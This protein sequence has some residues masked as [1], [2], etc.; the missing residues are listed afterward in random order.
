MCLLLL[1]T[2]P[3]FAAAPPGVTHACAPVH[4]LPRPC[5][6]ATE[7][8]TGTT[9][10]FEVTDATLN[11][12]NGIDANSIVATLSRPGAPPVT[13]F[14][15]NQVWGAGFTGRVIPQFTEN[16]RFG[17]GF[18]IVPAAPL[19]PSTTHTVTVTGNNSHGTPLDPATTS[20]SFTTR[21]SLGGAAL[22]WAVDAA[23]A[24]VNWEG[25][26]FAGECKV[27]FDSSRTYQQEAVY[28]LIDAARAAAPEFFL[29]QRDFPLLGDY[30]QATFFDGNLN[31]VR[32]RETRRITKFVDAAT[33]TELTLGELI[34]GPLYGI[35]PG[36][37]LSGDY[38]A[39]DRVLVCD[40]TRSETKKVQSVNDGARTIRVDK[41]TTPAALWNLGDPVLPADDPTIPDNFTHPLAALRKASPAGTPVYY[42]TRMD[43]EL[44][45]HVAHG[46][47]PLID[48]HDTP[49]DLCRTGVG[50]NSN[51]GTCPSSP[52]DWPEWH[53]FVRTVVGHLIDRYGA[54]VEEWN[55][56]IGNEPD[57]S[58]WWSSRPNEFF[59][60]Y[61]YTSNA[62]LKT[63]EEK[64]L[65]ASRVK[66][67]GPEDSGIF[68]GHENQ[69]L[70]HCSPTANNPDTTFVETNAVCTDA[71]FNA[72]RAAR[73]NALCTTS[74]NK[75]CPLDY[76]SLHSYRNAA[77]A[78]AVINGAR[79]R[80]LSIDAAYYDRLPVHSHETTPDWVPRRD[81][82]SREG[83]R[84]GGFFSSWG[85]DYF[86]RLLG[87]G[88]ADPRK[89]RGQ[90]VL[91]AWPFNYNFEGT[92]SIAGQFRI[93]VDGDGTQ[94]R[95][96]AVKTPFFEFAELAARMS[97]TLGALPTV[98]DAGTIVSGWRSV[99][100]AGDRIL[101]YAHDEK[102]TGGG[103]RGGWD[104]ALH[105]DN[106]RFPVVEVTEYRVDNEH[107]ARDALAAV[108]DRG[109]TG[110]YRPVEVAGVEASAQ[111]VPLGPPVRREITGG[112]LDLT[113]RV[114]GQG[115]TFV[116]L[117]RPD[118]DGDGVYEPDDNCPATVNPSQANSDSDAA[119]DACDCAPADGGAF[120]IPAEV[121][122]LTLDADRQTI[123]WASVAPNA[124][125]GTLHDLLRG[126]LGSWPVGGAGESCLGSTAGTSATDAAQPAPGTG[127][128][129]LV[130]GRNACGAGSW[131]KDSGGA[132]R[133]SGACP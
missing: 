53:D 124:G 89:A 82:G 132:D 14:G 115:I 87:A 102:D 74:A 1:V 114:L 65:D 18:Y 81:P 79:D 103:E 111:L 83:Y 68:P 98:T 17:F 51:G 3:A 38:H 16:D 20:W 47:R 91:T 5:D 130:R 21:R 119:G 113:S 33:Y 6:N 123:R 84:W 96:D 92:A 23:G 129:Y 66:V 75:G 120:A 49:F 4:A 133:S 99:E 100:P 121:T 97:H 64:G 62:I 27:E 24:T 7:V 80:S 48:F 39:N 127:F 90:A 86:R 2:L 93:D 76:L 35:T 118:P 67:G 107:G 72:K 88:L 34:E 50:E 109:S 71:A 126:P 131:G 106:L 112:H 95:V 60:Y 36:R 108:P 8:T 73:I 28:Q 15:P 59:K 85:G 57:L 31:L 45:Q 46:R 122:G 44:D 13:M 54:P 42:W 30:Y 22:D 116:E 94:D 9:I 29:Q 69:I 19:L 12:P 61:D 55:F 26:W 104:V 58:S 101:V 43:D 56:S 40:P 117:M 70:Y 37:P 32:E 41:L 77:A 125:S 63:F 25:R 52:K 78:F 10:Y 128:R 105:L 110:L 11:Y